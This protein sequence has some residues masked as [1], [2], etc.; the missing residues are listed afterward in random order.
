MKIEFETIIHI[1]T[2]TEEQNPQ[3]QLK[4]CLFIYK[5]KWGKYKLF[6]EKQSAWKDSIRD[7]FEEEKVLIKK[8]GIKHYICWD[9][10]RIY[11]NRKRLIS[12]FKF[13]KMH[14]CKIHSYRQQ[15]FES[16]HTMPEPFNEAM[17]DFMLQMMGWFAEDESN[18]KSDRVKSAVRKRGDITISYKGN[19]W[20]RKG[21]SKQKVSKIKELRNQGLS[22][23]EI[24][25]ELDISKSVVHKYLG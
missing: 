3:N 16:L 7:V 4:D 13:C 14:G 24:S 18:K 6:E 12:F 2:S 15:F 20:G 5:E 8:G 25:K 9:V 17:F 23:R 21:I 22:L 10:D 19:K 1:R 11:R